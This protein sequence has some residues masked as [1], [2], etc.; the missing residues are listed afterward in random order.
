MGK[1][2]RV[3]RGA[4]IVFPAADENGAVLRAAKPLAAPWNSSG[5]SV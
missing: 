2:V 5:R 1:G 3:G 4:R